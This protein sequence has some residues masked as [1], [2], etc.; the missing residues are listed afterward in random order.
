MP[1]TTLQEHPQMFRA[2]YTDNLS[3]ASTSPLSTVGIKP[4]LDGTTGEYVIYWDEI[5]KVFKNA[6]YIQNAGT[7]APF[8]KDKHSEW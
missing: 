3:M 6:V 7:A 8:L 4:T 2:V 1:E 5:L